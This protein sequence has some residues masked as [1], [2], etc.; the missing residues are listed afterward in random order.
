MQERARALRAAGKMWRAQQGSGYRRNPREIEEW[1]EYKRNPS[2]VDV[3]LYAG[4]ALAIYYYGIRP[5]MDSI[6]KYLT[7]PA[8]AAADGGA[9]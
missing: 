8:A 7:P 3:A 5:N 4:A 6:K 2:G 9:S 1:R